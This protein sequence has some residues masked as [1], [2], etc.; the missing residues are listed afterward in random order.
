[1]SRGKSG[2]LNYGR[3]SALEK[4][5]QLGEADLVYLKPKSLAE[6]G[7]IIDAMFAAS[8][9]SAKRGGP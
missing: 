8:A 1:M 6:V 5:P 2:E 7:Q 4:M 9:R 3:H